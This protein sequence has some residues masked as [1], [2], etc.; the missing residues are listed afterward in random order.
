MKRFLYILLVFLL[1]CSC[2]TNAALGGYNEA[3]VKN[4]SSSPNLEEKAVEEKQSLRGYHADSGQTTYEILMEE[5]PEYAEVCTEVDTTDYLPPEFRQIRSDSDAYLNILTYED[6]ET[7]GTFNMHIGIFPDQTEAQEE[8]IRKI[9]LY[10][11]MSK[12]Y[13]DNI[14]DIGD[15]R[16]SEY[17]GRDYIRDFCFIRGNVFVSMS[18]FG[19]VSVPIENIAKD[20]DEYIL[21]QIQ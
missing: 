11:D 7:E 5:I 14:H 13:V 3:T 4:K 18:T 17:A 1:F 6:R 19:V 9:S 20:I 10:A 15:I 16:F 2:S 12:P 21:S 8:F